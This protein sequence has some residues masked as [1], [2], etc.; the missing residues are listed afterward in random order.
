[1][2]KIEAIIRPERISSVKARLI[3]I[4]VGGMTLIDA[5][6]WSK[7]RELHLQWRGQKIAYDLVP[8]IKI[9]IIVPDEVADSVIK[10]IIETAKTE[11][12]HAGDGIVFVSTI[13]KSISIGGPRADEKGKEVISSS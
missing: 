7:E 13:D 1:M 5:S 10:S 6:G 12:G 8:K 4:G 2:K 11:D 3:E 9:E